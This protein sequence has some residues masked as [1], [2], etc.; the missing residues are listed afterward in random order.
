VKFLGMTM[1]GG[2]IAHQALRSA[3]HKVKEWTPRGTH[4]TLETTLEQINT[5]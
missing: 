3:R 1:V 5:R 2:A 4:Q